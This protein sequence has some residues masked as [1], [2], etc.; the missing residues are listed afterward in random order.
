MG[1][2]SIYQLLQKREIVFQVQRLQTG[3]SGKPI[4]TNSKTPQFSLPPTTDD[5]KNIIDFEKQRNLSINSCGINLAYNINSIIGFLRKN[6]VKCL[7]THRFPWK[8]ATGK[9]CPLLTK[10]SLPTFLIN[11]IIFTGSFQFIF[12]CLEDIACFF[13]LF[14][15]Y[16]CT[17]ANAI[18]I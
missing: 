10:L 18:T 5:E 6:S 13:S 4:L 3:Q 15:T 14:W 1:D 8:L 12:I 16:T 7:T 17:L 2:L 11:V 9:F